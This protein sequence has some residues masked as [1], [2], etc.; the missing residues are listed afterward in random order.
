VPQQGLADGG[1]TPG[2]HESDRECGSNRTPQAA[3]SQVSNGYHDEAVPCPNNDRRR[4]ENEV[5]LSCTF[6]GRSDDAQHRGYTV[7]QRVI[8]LCVDNICNLIQTYGWH[9]VDR[10]LQN[11]SR[12]REFICSMLYLMR[13]GIT[14]KNQT[15]L[16]RME[17]LNT[18]LPLQVFLPS[19]F[20]IRAKSITEGENIIK[21]DLQ[22][23]PL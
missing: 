22:R 15:I 3:T 18:L 17:I 19:I 10:Q 1:R 23:I 5:R 11:A 4:I 6:V 8:R 7:V 13:M 14:F 20:G 9:R 16:Q 2:G 12:G 21:L